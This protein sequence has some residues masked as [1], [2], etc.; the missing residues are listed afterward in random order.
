[1][2]SVPEPALLK[3]QKSELAQ[4]SEIAIVLR[5]RRL[6]EPLGLADAPLIVQ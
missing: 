5:E 1:M 4:C 3:P 6:I 2:L